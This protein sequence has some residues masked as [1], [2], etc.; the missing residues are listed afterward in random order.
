MR[1]VGF[2]GGIGQVC[3]PMP[4]FTMGGQD[5]QDCGSRDNV[6]WFCESGYVPF[7]IHDDAVLVNNGTPARATVLPP[8][9]H[10]RGV[11]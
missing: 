5:C 4:C 9:K 1:C 2:N 3:I 6:E 10:V 11:R 8:V 7:G